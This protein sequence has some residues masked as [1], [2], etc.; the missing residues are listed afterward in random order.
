MVPCPP[1][2]RSAPH[3]KNLL[4]RCKTASGAEAEDPLAKRRRRER[5]QDAAQPGSSSGSCGYTTSVV[6]RA[7]AELQPHPG[8]STSGGEAEAMLETAAQRQHGQGRSQGNAVGGDGD[9]AAEQPSQSEPR[10]SKQEK[11]PA[12]QRLAEVLNRVKRRRPGS[13]TSSSQLPVVLT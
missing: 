3:D 10:S 4:I 2:D 9:E 11:R 13:G 8:A 6:P 5:Q 12:A 7:A 1:C